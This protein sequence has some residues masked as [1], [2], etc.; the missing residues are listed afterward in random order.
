LIPEEP[1]EKERNENLDSSI[2]IKIIVDR[3][4]DCYFFIFPRIFSA[5]KRT[6]K[7]LYRLGYFQGRERWSICGSNVFFI[8]I[9]RWNAGFLVCDFGLCC[10]RD[11]IA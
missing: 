2:K 8:Y 7:D 5:T 10:F 3:F 9:Y 11:S 6:V 1:R 4:Y